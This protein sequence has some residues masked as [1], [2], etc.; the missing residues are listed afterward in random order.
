[1]TSPRELGVPLGN[2]PAGTLN[3]LTDVAGVRVGHTTV[4]ADATSEHD[5]IRTGVTAIWPHEGLPWREAVYAGA[6]VLNGHGELIGVCQ[7]QEWGL[8]RSPIMLTSSLSIGA[9]YDGVARWAAARDPQLS[10]G[11]FFMPVVTEVSDLALSD[12]RAF[13]ITPA[14]VA[15]ALESASAERPAEGGVG[16]GTG[17]VCYDLKGGIGTASRLVPFDG[18]QATIGALVLTNYGERRNLT[19]GGVEIGPSLD[20]PIPP[21]MPTEGSAVVVLAT[22]APLAPHQL[23]RLALR[24]GVGLTRSGAFVGQ[25]SGEIVIAFSTANRV[26][27]EPAPTVDVTIASD[28]FNPSFNAFFEAT[29]EA[30]DEA[31]LNS[32]FAAE[33][34]V[35]CQGIEVPALPRE[36]VAATL[37][38][39]GA[40]A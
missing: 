11:N 12:N 20:L 31:V 22:D 26:G 28:G 35:G 13:P 27:W 10:R 5:A 16:A 34:T 33:T 40:I 8:L 24:G 37:R 38:A 6:A 39:R 4:V 25:T 9:V 21:A 23:S 2:F 17:T 15:Q 29:L 36:A 14:H 32:L 3:A 18:G 19:I 7:I 1:M 30:V